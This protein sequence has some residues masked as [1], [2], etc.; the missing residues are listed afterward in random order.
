MSL[1]RS[2]SRKDERER[3]P[4]GEEPGTEERKGLS[5][6]WGAGKKHPQIVQGEH[7]AGDDCRHR[8]SGKTREKEDTH[9]GITHKLLWAPSRV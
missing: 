9:L 2:K 4:E 3:P 1:F 6:A 8:S 7:G 5:H